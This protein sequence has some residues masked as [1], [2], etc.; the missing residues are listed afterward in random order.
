MKTPA[1][2]HR[3]GRPGAAER[4]R[5]AAVAC[6][7]AVLS[8]SAKGLLAQTTEVQQG[9]WK[10]QINSG[11]CESLPLFTVKGPGT[12]FD[13]AN[14]AALTAL[15]GALGQAL[16]KVCPEAREVIL[17]SGR[18]RRLT[19]LPAES[20]T[21]APPAP[22]QTPA[23]SSSGAP[24][25][26]QPADQTP[27]LQTRQNAAAPPLTG[28]AA[29]AVT[30]PSRLP[31]LASAHDEEAKCDV[32]FQWLESGK[33]STPG[34]WNARATSTQMMAVFR[35][36]PVTAV[37][38]KPY[39]QIDNRERI[40]LQQK[41][42]FPCM[43]I[44]QPSRPVVVPFVGVVRGRPH[45]M[46]PQYRQEFAQYYNLLQEAFGGNPGPYEPANVIRY[47]GQIRQQIA[48]ANSSMSDAAA[49]TVSPESFRKLKDLDGSIASQL[50]LL[51]PEERDGVHRYLAQR[52]GELAQGILTN[53]INASKSQPATKE[54]A[55]ALLQSHSRM[56]E[57]MSAADASTRA[58]AEAE[59]NQLLDRDVRDTLQAE[60]AK[61]AAIP[62]N[63]DGARQLGNA[64]SQFVNSFAKYSQT[65]S[66]SQALAEFSQARTRVYSAALPA[67]QKEVG[68]LPLQENDI[69][70]RR[71]DLNILFGSAGDRSSPLY[72]EFSKPLNDKEAQLQ[73]K[74][75]ADE[76]RRLAEAEKAAEEQARRE[77][78]ANGRAASPGKSASGGA[79]PT[80]GVLS[81]AALVVPDTPNGEILKSIYSGEFDKVDAD[82][83]GPLFQAIG[84]GY[85]Q[86]F[87]DHCRKFLPADRIQLTKSVCDMEQVTT[88]GWGV[89]TSETCVSWEQV[90]IDEYADPRLYSAL[91][92]TP[93][94]TVASAM[95]T[96]MNV[97]SGNVSLGQMLGSVGTTVDASSAA[98]NLSVSN[99]CTSA[100][101]HRFQQNLQRFALGED[102]IRLNGTEEIGV[103]LLPPAPG[104]TY[105]DSD[106]G[107]LL[108]D[109]VEE[110]SASWAVN[111]FVSG[112]V[113]GV[114]VDSRDAAGRPKEVSARYRFQGFSGPQSGTVTLNFEDGRPK[115]LYFSDQ[116][117]ICRTPA[118]SITSAYI[119]GKYR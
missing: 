89:Q 36:E 71:Q 79:W 33:V 107:R 3:S 42:F 113:G 26:A 27:T 64:E 99:S 62:A 67:W 57:V 25:A 85:I 15:T 104:E 12:L 96:A 46:P 73:A 76:R 63:L 47:L 21:A 19:R 108:E 83:S 101:L 51:R 9:S 119:E 14:S 39:D 54:S 103:A 118:H 91:N 81:A 16:R 31:S 32:A 66:Y 53:W 102:G 69:A 11:S 40:E 110:E 41:V 35:D 24:P 84:S 95:R 22:V 78:A 87:S 68:A 5:N 34:N 28:S 45:P 65:N 8:M 10:I 80:S 20:E 49:A 55:D 100:A 2:T 92:S 38:G 115:C 52:E 105:R 82:R 1:R 116:P 50:S 17:V 58:S 72:Q 117:S 13:S 7:L 94:Q 59:Y 48:W 43:G 29:P 6:T 30:A 109:M 77:A 112:S 75:E 97:M 70:A 114:S 44:Q 18:T 106:Y 23:A 90:P 111:R 74:V 61:L 86:G 93:M 88:N 60:N 37:F 56:N 4:F 98:A